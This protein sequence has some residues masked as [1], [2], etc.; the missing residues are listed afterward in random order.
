MRNGTDKK[1]VDGNDLDG[2]PTGKAWYNTP[3]KFNSCS[4]LGLPAKLLFFDGDS[5][6]FRCG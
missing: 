3:S 2:R 6:S 4:H 5:F 1:Q